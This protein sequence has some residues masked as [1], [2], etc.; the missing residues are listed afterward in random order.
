[1]KK[2]Y[3]MDRNLLHIS[4]EAGAMEDPWYD[5]TTEADT[6]MY[7]L[8]V[9]PEAAPDKPQYLQLLFEKGNVIGFQCDDQEELMASLPDVT[10][11]GERDGYTLCTPYGIMRVLITLGGKPSRSATASSRNTPNSS[12]TA[13]GSPRSARRSRPSSPKP[14]RR[15]PE[16]SA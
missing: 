1:M 6:D 7:T 11:T 14:R 16:R 3:S 13:S 10:P 15:S 8:S 12:T 4:Y 9:S 2:P 5:A